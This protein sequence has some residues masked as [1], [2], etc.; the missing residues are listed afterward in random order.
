[1]KT[2]SLTLKVLIFSFVIIS[3]SASVRAQT[4]LNDPDSILVGDRKLPEV[5]LVGTFHFAYYNLDAH[6][7]SA[8]QQVDILSPQKQAE[9]N[10]L[11]EY[12]YKFR[13]NKIA[14]ESGPITEYLINKYRRYLNGEYTLGK[15]ER[16]QIGFRLMQKFNIDTIYGVD[17][18]PVVNEI[19]M[20]KDSL[21]IRPVLDSIFADYDFRSNDT[22]SM[23][24]KEYNEHDDLIAT[25]MPL[26]DYFKYT[27]SDKVLNRGFGA[28]LNGD[29]KLGDF[30]GADALSMFWYNRNLRIFR[31]IQQITT[32][33][34]DRILVLYGSGHMQILKHLFECSPQYKLVKF[35][36]LE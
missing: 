36:E 6:V 28:Y 11:L 1:M 22:I 35:G 29:F 9:M 26:L 32:S 10:D 17:V 14:V 2:I 27:N 8:D 21:A 30:R 31:R 16:E 34:D 15:D 20:I 12:I 5:F 19:Y 24:Y 25:Q 33:P 18:Q 23:L 4:M 7:T 13:P 3:T